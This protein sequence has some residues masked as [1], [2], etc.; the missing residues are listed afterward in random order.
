MFMSYHSIEQKQSRNMNQLR[1]YGK[2]FKSQ[3]GMLGFHYNPVDPGNQPTRQQTEWMFTDL[4]K[5]IRYQAKPC[6]SQNVGWLGENFMT[7]NTE[8]GQNDGL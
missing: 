7:S 2:G 1:V 5:Y 4:Q 3:T 6:W 8:A